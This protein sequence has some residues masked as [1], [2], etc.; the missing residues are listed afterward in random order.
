MAK[1]EELN[2]DLFAGGSISDGEKKNKSKKNSAKKAELN[3]KKAEKLAAK[4]AKYEEEIKTLKEK[5]SSE[6]DEAKKQ[7]LGKQLDKAKANLEKVG[8][9]VNIANDQKKIIKSVVAVVVVVAIL[10]TY[11]STGL[12]RKGFVHSTLQWTTHLTAITV[13]SDDGD[14]IKVPVST[15]NYYFAT[16]YNNLMSTKQLYDQYGLDASKAGLD[17]DFDKPLSKQKTTNE[18]DEVV[19]WAKYLEDMV[20]KSIEHTYTLYNEAVK[21]N[22]GKEPEITEEQQKQIDDT[23]KQYK[24]T[25]NKYG[26]TLSAYLVKAMGKGVT[27]SVFREESKRS[28]IAENYEKELNSKNEKVEI[29]DEDIAK[30]KDEHLEDLKSVDVRIFEANNEDEAVEFKNALKA[31]GSNFTDLCVK[32]AADGFYKDYYKDAGASTELS[33]TKT[34]LQNAGYAIATADKKDG[35]DDEKTYSGLDWL[36]SSERAK[37][38]IYQKSTTVVYVLTPARLS[39]V[40]TVNVRHILIA[41]ETKGKDNNAVNASAESW[42]AANKKAQEILAK[43]NKGKKTENSFAELAKANSSDGSANNGGL[44]ENVYPNQMVSTFNNWC[45]DSNRKAGDVDI[46]KTEYGYHIMYFVGATGTPAWKNTAK[47]ELTNKASKTESDKLDEAYTA[48]LNWFGSRYIEKDVDID[49]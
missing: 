14:K 45:F 7:E 42:D 28:Y 5:I 2:D 15:Y 13:K 27:E 38:D 44:Y 48:K 46:V 29:K 22:D 18:D 23:L 34:A 41:P 4:R 11:V 24:E 31:D 39:D 43:Y 9:G 30:Y 36:F 17:V 21:A 6:N 25:A 8:K 3:A 20:V 16:T 40:N 47:T 33:A 19:T 37:G 1:K 49:R 10:V 35:K 32:Y 12:V 26:F